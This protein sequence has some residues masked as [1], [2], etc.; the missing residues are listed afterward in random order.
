MAET[1]LAVISAGLVIAPPTTRAK[2]P[3]SKAFLPAPDN[4]YVLRQ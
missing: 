3:A 1:N 2:A 4:G